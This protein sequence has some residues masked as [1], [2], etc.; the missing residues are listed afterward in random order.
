MTRTLFVLSIKGRKTQHYVASMHWLEQNHS[1]FRYFPFSGCVLHLYS[2]LCVTLQR[3]SS[4]RMQENVQSAWRSW[5]RGTPSLGCPASASTI[6]G[7]EL[8]SENAASLLPFLTTNRYLSFVSA[9]FIQRQQHALDE[10]VVKI[11]STEQYVQVLEPTS[12]YFCSVTCCMAQKEL[13]KF[14]SLVSPCFLSC[15][16]EWFE[17][18]RSCPEHPSD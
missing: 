17:V 15:I 12:S 14:I 4:L 3:T 9:N 2:C 1:I 6:K 7:R 13:Q 10:L 16:D 18:N 11:L 8:W 5:C